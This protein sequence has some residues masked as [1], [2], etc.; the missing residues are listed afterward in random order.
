MTGWF[1]VL[2]SCQ[3]PPPPQYQ[4]SHSGF[5]NKQLWAQ[6]SAQEAIWW[7][8]AL[9]WS[10]EEES[11]GVFALVFLINPALLSAPVSSF[12]FHSVSF[13]VSFFS[14]CSSSLMLCHH[15][16]EHCFLS[17]TCH[18]SRLMSPLPSL[19]LIF[20]A[21]SWLFWPS[22]WCA[23][24]NLNHLELS[25]LLPESCVTLW[26]IDGC[27]KILCVKGVWPCYQTGDCHQFVLE[28]AYSG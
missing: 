11:S 2:E 18:G 20:L 14:Y 4:K 26:K 8:T 5:E 13:S 12:L 22:L 27:V 16:L 9:R 28:A 21:N 6:L 15:Y 24:W 7:G 10:C 23:V 25:A 3:C 17:S 1:A 19:L